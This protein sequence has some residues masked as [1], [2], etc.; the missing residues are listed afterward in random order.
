MIHDEM[1]FPGKILAVDC[2][3]VVVTAIQTDDLYQDRTK[4]RDVVLRWGRPL[5]SR[6]LDDLG[7]GE[8]GG[9]G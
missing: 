4:R 2:D 3:N 1:F 6:P 7:T 9:S 5:R 8:Y